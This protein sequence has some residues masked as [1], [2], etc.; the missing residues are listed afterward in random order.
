MSVNL[1]YNHGF[2]LFAGLMKNALRSINVAVIF[3]AMWLWFGCQKETADTN[4]GSESNGDLHERTKPLRAA[5]LVGYD[6]TRLRK[7]V[8]R[9]IDANE[10][11]NQK[12]EKMTEG[13]PDQ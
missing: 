4:P 6:G 10:K 8:D 7:S 2:S 5:D 11:H 12:L 13:S 1:S 9:I 3:S